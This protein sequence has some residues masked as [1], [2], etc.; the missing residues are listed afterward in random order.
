[1]LI[2]YFC[3]F[4]HNWKISLYAKNKRCF[5]LIYLEQYRFHV[6]II[7]LSRSNYFTSLMTNQ[8]QKLK[9]CKV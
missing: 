8:T 9:N 1:M 6:T 3:I 4:N 2:E 7:Y 5:Y